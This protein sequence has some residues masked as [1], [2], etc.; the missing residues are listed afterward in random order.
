MEPDREEQQKALKPSAATKR[1]RFRIVKLE[2][3]IAPKQSGNG[4][5]NGHN[6]S[7]ICQTTSQP[8]Y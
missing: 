4:K 1:Q 8:S 6:F 7:C 2:E 5:T 3:R